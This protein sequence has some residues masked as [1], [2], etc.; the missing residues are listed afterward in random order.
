MSTKVTCFRQR[1][2]K[3]IPLIVDN[4]L[5]IFLKPLSPSSDQDRI[6]PYTINVIS[7]RLVMRIKKISIR[8]LLVDPI[9][10]SQN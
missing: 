4:T 3:F 1:T 6:S 9:P 7:S 10:N 8:G 2:L 5:K